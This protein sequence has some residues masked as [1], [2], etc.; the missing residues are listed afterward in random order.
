MKDPQDEIPVCECCYC[1]GEIYRGD[2]V[3]AV[4]EGMLHVDEDCVFGYLR[5][6]YFPSELMM[7]L[8]IPQV[9]V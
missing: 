4:D 5:K 8:R 9:T 1:G 6:R 3:W 7:D 2:L